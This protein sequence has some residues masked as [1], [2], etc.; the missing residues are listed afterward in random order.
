MASHRPFRPRPDLHLALTHTGSPRTPNMAAPTSSSFSSPYRT[1]ITTP[2]PTAS[3]SPFQSGKL[4]VPSPFGGP[5]RFTP[6]QKHKYR[7]YYRAAWHKAKRLLASRVTWLIF[8]MLLMMAWWANG[9][10]G[11]L[12]AV[13]FGGAR[14]GRDFFKN[15]VTRDMQ[16]FP[17][18]N[19]KINPLNAPAVTAHDDLSNPVP[20]SGHVS[21]RPESP[22]AKP[23]AP[24]S[25]LARIDQEE[26]VL[27]PNSSFLVSICSGSLSRDEVHNIRIIAPMTDDHG[28]GMIQLE[29]LWLSKGGQF[30]RIDG[31]IQTDDFE[32]Q[33]I[34]GA[35]NDEVGG[36]HQSGLRKLLNGHKRNG[37]GGGQ[38]VLKDA[39]E[40]QDF[41]D[42]RKILEII[43]DT[44]GSF[45]RRR[46]VKRSGGADGL[47]AGVMG[48]EY[49]LGEMFGV[50]HVAIGVD[51]MCLT[52]ECIGGTG[53]PAG[54][55]DVFFRSGPPGSTYV[56]HPWLF[57]RYVPDIMVLNLGNA[58][59]ASF[60]AHAAEYNKT[61]WD[62]SERFENTYVSLVKAIR[63][64]AYPKH[65]ATIQSERSGFKIYVPNSVPAN[66]PIFIMRPLRGELEHATQN[67]AN[68]LRAEGDAAVFWLDTSGWLDPTVSESD[69]ESNPDAP[70]PE[71]QNPNHANNNNNQNEDYCLDRSSAS[72]PKYRLTE[73]GNQRT[74][75][76][77][78]MHVCRYLAR[79]GEKCS[80]LPQEVYAGKVFDPAERDFERYVEG[81]KE[82][83]LRRLFW[84]VGEGEGEGGKGVVGGGGGGG[85][86]AGLGGER[87]DVV[88][89]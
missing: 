41:R 68:R 88:V 9:G 27:L 42:R 87:G 54:L 29:G 6:R 59:Q 16:F 22:N 76:F 47:L 24:V 38:R 89:G 36:K 21:F 53:E 70:N 60:D 40:L 57:N 82:K 66:I 1:P 17:P 12:D 44:P 48:W 19:P 51:G 45:S 75:I 58:D 55:G 74:A 10:S 32:D 71:N 37:L 49:L 80:F 34:M 81:E 25:L 85:G 86:E 14:F 50:D 33:D 13:R 26:Y 43:S 5:M 73:R 4:N 28:Q 72:A 63:T 15:G 65:P 77:L 31:T 46:Q 23:A 7:R 62:L 83:K 52:Q 2:L 84:G 64:L 56:E 30:E 67:I 69:P 18:S 3:D 39:E 61:L 79:E 78:H 8:V 35:E 11:E 20:H